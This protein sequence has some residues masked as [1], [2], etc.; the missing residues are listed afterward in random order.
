MITPE[1]RTRPIPDQ[2]LERAQHDGQRRRRVALGAGGGTAAAVV[3]VVLALGSLGSGGAQSLKVVDDPTPT[4]TTVPALPDAITAASPAPTGSASARAGAQPSATCGTGGCAGSWRDEPAPGDPS[5]A[6]DSRPAY[7]ESPT[8]SV[9][10]T[11][12]GV[13]ANPDTYAFCGNPSGPPAT[14]RSGE[15]AEVSYRFCK[16]ADAHVS[17]ELGYATGQEQELVVSRGGVEVWRFSDTV[18]YAQGAHTRTLTTGNCLLWGLSWPGATPAGDPVPPGHYTLSYSF[19]PRTLD[20]GDPG[21]FAEP[22][23]YEVDVTG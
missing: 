23:T 19:T 14:L 2:G 3:A 10:T 7:T 15:Q 11:C 20:G 9:S 6:A 21:S 8:S 12:T 22:R 13:A 18:R 1:K 16:A 5:P 4:V 17:L